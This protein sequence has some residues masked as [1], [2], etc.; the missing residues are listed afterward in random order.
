[1]TSCSPETHWKLKVAWNSMWTNSNYRYYV[2]YVQYRYILSTMQPRIFTNFLALLASYFA[3]EI[4]IGN[5][6]FLSP[7]LCILW[8]PIHFDLSTPPAAIDQSCSPHLINSRENTHRAESQSAVVTN[9]VNGDLRVF[10]EHLD[11]GS[12]APRQKIKP[13]D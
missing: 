7:V 12:F 1:M 9:E 3:L 5:T 11:F 2:N 8:N 6:H 10:G 13:A 4:L